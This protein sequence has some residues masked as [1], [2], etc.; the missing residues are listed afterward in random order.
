MTPAIVNGATKK[1]MMEPKIAAMRLMALPER[2][3]AKPLR[4]QE[5]IVFLLS[6]EAQSI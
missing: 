4:R 6:R 5:G 1:K 3:H 2:S